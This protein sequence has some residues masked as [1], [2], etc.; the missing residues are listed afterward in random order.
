M[1]RIREQDEVV[2]A[3][4]GMRVGK[5][6]AGLVR[7]SGRLKG[8]ADKRRRAWPTCKDP[9]GNDMHDTIKATYDQGRPKS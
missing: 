9:R 6:V 7:L 5:G 8:V 4:N 3:G 2:P 1:L